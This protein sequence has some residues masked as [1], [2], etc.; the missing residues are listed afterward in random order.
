LE[1]RRNSS[2]ETDHV[3]DVDL[4][5]SDEDRP[6]ANGAVDQLGKKRDQSFN[7]LVIEAILEFLEREE[8]A[9]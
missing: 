6:E 1:G 8:S 2:A 7:Y 9:R 3:Q 5:S 4:H